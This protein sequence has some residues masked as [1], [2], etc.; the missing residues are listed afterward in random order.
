MRSLALIILPCAVAVVVHL[1]LTSPTTTS[2]ETKDSGTL[3]I[4]VNFYRALKLVNFREAALA[5]WVCLWGLLWCSGTLV[6]C[7][8]RHGF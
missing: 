2:Q 5:V 3:C 1:W 8:S 6:R 4:Y 7:L